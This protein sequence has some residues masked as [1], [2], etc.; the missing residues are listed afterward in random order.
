MILLGKREIIWKGRRKKW[1]PW[2]EYVTETKIIKKNS[3]CVTFGTSASITW[4]IHSFT[5]GRPII[6]TTTQFGDSVFQYSL[7]TLPNSMFCIPYVTLSHK[8]SIISHTLPCPQLQIPWNLQLW[9]TVSMFIKRN[10]REKKRY[11]LTSFWVFSDVYMFGNLRVCYLKWYIN[12]GC[13][14]KLVEVVAV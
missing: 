6:M 7:V 2:D 1:K 14:P 11:F 8:T 12:E 9:D 5:I 10:F 13:R 4:F 3:S